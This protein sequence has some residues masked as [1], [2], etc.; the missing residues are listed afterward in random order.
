MVPSPSC[1]QRGYLLKI[2]EVT[3]VHADKRVIRENFGKLIQ[4]GIG[5]Q[6]IPIVN[7]HTLVGEVKPTIAAQ[8]LDEVDM[9]S[10]KKVA[11]A[12]VAQHDPA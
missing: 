10:Q 12:A 7:I 11:H 5:Q 1:L 6:R 4:R 2:H 3:S 9:P 8:T